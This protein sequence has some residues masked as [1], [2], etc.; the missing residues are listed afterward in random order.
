MAGVVSSPLEATNLSIVVQ[1]SPPET[2]AH[3]V[4]ALAITLDAREIAFTDSPQGKNCLL[5]FLF[6]QQD[7]TGKQVG[8]EEKHAEFNSSQKKYES[9]VQSGMLVTDHLPLADGATVLKIVVRDQRSGMI[10]SVTIPLRFR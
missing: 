5:D 4:T 7:D 6:V 3:K 9:L 10:G 1:V 2:T 8:G